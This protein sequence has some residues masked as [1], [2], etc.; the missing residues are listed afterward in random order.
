MNAASRLVVQTGAETQVSVHAPPVTGLLP[1]TRSC[2]TLRSN[3]TRRFG[4]QPRWGTLGSVADSGAQAP[5]LTD[6]VARGRRTGHERLTSAKA[7]LSEIRC[8]VA[9]L[10]NRSVGVCGSPLA[11]RAVQAFLSVAPEPFGDLHAE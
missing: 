2:E 6:L 3:F 1:S 10:G 11:N 4:G 7:C 8:L 9:C 5:A